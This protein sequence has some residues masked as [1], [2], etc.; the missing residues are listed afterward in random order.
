M[1]SAIRWASESVL[2]ARWATALLACSRRS[3]AAVRALT[4]L[5]P[6]V[7]A[8]AVGSACSS[9][10]S[11]ATNAKDGG[12]GAASGTKDGGLDSG[13]RA[14]PT[15][16]GGLGDGSLDAAPTS[17][18]SYGGACFSGPPGSPCNC[19]AGTACQGSYNCLSSS[20]VNG[21]CA[22]VACSPTCTVGSTCSVGTDCSS[23]VCTQFNC[24]PVGTPQRCWQTATIDAGASVCALA[25]QNGLDSQDGW[26]AFSTSTG[27]PDGPCIAAAAPRAPGLRRRHHVP[28]GH[29]RGDRDVRPV[30]GHRRAPAA[31]LASA[32]LASVATT[33]GPCACVRRSPESLRAGEMSGAPTAAAEDFVTDLC[34]AK[35]AA[36]SNTGTCSA[37]ACPACGG[38]GQPCCPPSN[39]C[40]PS[41]SGESGSGCCGFGMCVMSGVVGNGC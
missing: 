25:C 14:S 12:R 2:P 19:P 17:C 28:G 26:Y 1:A 30:R 18:P 24:Q 16:D 13:L 41:A 38:P 6:L 31:S 27:G 15:K 5:I 10:G 35:G 21:S 9:P 23:G 4:R 33:A 7:M 8:A 3:R 20:C 11:Q 29:E 22:P 40:G 39:T 36:C 32:T 37:V 34:V